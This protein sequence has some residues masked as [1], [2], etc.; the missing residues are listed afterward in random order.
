MTF[1][2]SRVSEHSGIMRIM[3]LCLCYDQLEGAEIACMELL[4]RRAQ[5]VELKFKD[6]VLPK[7]TKD[8]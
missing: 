2:A 8:I 3:A 6:R 4:A 5:M 1:A 7:P